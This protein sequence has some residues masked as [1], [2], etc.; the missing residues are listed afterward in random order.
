MWH[1]QVTVD[2]SGDSIVR[3]WDD[4]RVPQFRV[5]IVCDSRSFRKTLGEYGTQREADDIAGWFGTGGN[6]RAEVIPING[7][8]QVCA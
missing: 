5:D 2:G 7:A 6:L 4:G 1:R 8:T 3:T